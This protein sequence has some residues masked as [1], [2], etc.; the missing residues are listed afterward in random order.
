[1]TD[2]DYAIEAPENSMM[3][4]AQLVFVGVPLEK[5][6]QARAL[7]DK[8]M[9]PFRLS[10]GACRFPLAVQIVTARNRAN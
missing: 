4:D 1:V 6:P 5:M 7:V 2:H 10:S 9:A 3:D 8:H